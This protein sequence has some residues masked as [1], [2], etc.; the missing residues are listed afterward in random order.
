VLLL[1]MELSYG[2]AYVFP[3]KKPQYVSASQFKYRQFAVCAA[4][5]WEHEVSTYCIKITDDMA[6]FSENHRD[7]YIIAKKLHE[8]MTEADVIVAHNG[9]AFDIKWANTLFADYDLGPIPEKKSIDTLKVARKYF[10]FEGNS[11]S[12][13]LRRF[14]LGSKAAKPDWQKLTDGCEKEIAKAAKYCKIDVI[15]LEKIYKKLRPFIR[16]MPHHRPSGGFIVQCHACLSKNIKSNGKSFDGKG[17]YQRVRCGE[18]GHEMREKVRGH[19]K[20]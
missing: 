11:L 2:L 20:I 3:S 19:E 12:D 4:Y 16:K 5:K 9:D 14:G 10:N 17:L 7:S 18:C 6:R 8:V 13:L 1:D 15:K